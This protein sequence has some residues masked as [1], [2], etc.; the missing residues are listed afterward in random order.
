MQFFRMP[1]FPS[2]FFFPVPLFPEPFFPI[3]SQKQCI[4]VTRSAKQTSR[5]LGNDQ[6]CLESDISSA[7]QKYPCKYTNPHCTIVNCFIRQ[8]S[9]RK[10]VL[11][12]GLQAGPSVYFHK[13]CLEHIFLELKYMED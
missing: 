7:T 1:F 12:V 8:H 9:D 2:A 11:P 10:M 6:L 5:E 13:L 3:H 4:G